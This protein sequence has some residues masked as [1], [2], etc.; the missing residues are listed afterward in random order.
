MIGKMLGDVLNFIFLYVVF[1]VPFAV[2][3]FNIFG[4]FDDGIQDF[5][6]VAVTFMSLFRMTVIDLDYG[7]LRDRDPIMAPLLV[8]LW[9]FLSGILFINLF[10]AM[11]SNTF[12]NIADN[13]NSVAMME[14]L[15]AVLSVQDLLNYED[16][17][18]HRKKIEDEASEEHPDVETFDD[19]EE[20]NLK[21]K[22]LLFQESVETKF[23]KLEG[24]MSK[25]ETGLEEVVQ[26]IEAF[27]LDRIL[28]CIPQGQGG[29]D[30]PPL[31]KRKSSTKVGVTTEEANALKEQ[32]NL[33][34]SSGRFDNLNQKKVLFRQLSKRQEKSI[35]KHPFQ[36]PSKIEIDE[37][38]D[39]LQKRS[40]TASA[41]I[42]FKAT[43]NADVKRTVVPSHKKKKKRSGSNSNQYLN[44]KDEEPKTHKLKQ[45]DAGKNISMEDFANEMEEGESFDVT[46]KYLFGD[47]DADSSRDVSE[48]VMSPPN[49]IEEREEGEVRVEVDG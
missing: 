34:D 38:G 4:D 26:K 28:K 13:S 46:D 14:H 42:L 17:E 40:E 43:S 5:E 31:R 48:R 9:I 20:E 49:E 27:D 7:V 33:L 3:F 37:K 19:D 36:Q 2:A 41:A 12:Q 10:I 45:E 44:Y 32:I 11:M 35:P 23:D 25:L 8:F 39:T 16:L 47:L 30:A 22:E 29:R 18:N 1:L 21:D 6:N 24:N 15:E